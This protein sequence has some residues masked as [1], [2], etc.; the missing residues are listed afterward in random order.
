MTLLPTFLGIGS[1]RS[2]TTSLYKLLDD[3]PDVFMA[4]PKEL[5]Y[6]TFRHPQVVGNKGMS[7]QQYE[8]HFQG[9]GNAIARGEISPSYMWFPGAADRIKAELGILPLLVMLRNPIERVCSGYGRVLKIG[10]TSS[11]FQNFI[12]EGMEGLQRK[13]QSFDNHHPALLLQKSFYYQ[14]L[15][16]YI[17][18]FGRK[19][20]H[21]FL[22]ENMVNDFPSFRRGV[23][24]VINVE[25]RPSTPLPHVNASGLN[26]KMGLSEQRMLREIF[27]HD[28]ELTAELLDADLE[29]WLV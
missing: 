15:K 16:Y 7:Q 17:E 5:H 8:A 4:N 3:H 25:D 2:G 11:S 24:D 9:A 13:E 28:I 6:F 19:N 23:F 14:S 26:E 12:N 20:I 1:A 10:K 18:L 29:H 21:W 27:R 22:F